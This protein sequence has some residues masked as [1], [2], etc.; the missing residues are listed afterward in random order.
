M[1]HSVSGPFKRMQRIHHYM[2][3][4]LI[5][6][7]GLAFYLNYS[8]NVNPA[9]QQADH[10]LQVIAILVAITFYLGGNAYLRKKIEWI[11]LGGAEVTAK[12]EGFRRA[13]V[14]QWSL[15]G[16]AATF[17][18]LSFLLVGNYAFFALAI[19]IA[20][21]LAMNAPGKSRISMLLQI[22]EEEIV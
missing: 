5:I 18:I 6:L 21:L 4:V 19:A 14:T 12:L 22:R 10:L 20:I 15:L 11:R 8:G 16:I 9:L 13:S 3:V 1:S 7:T 2:L 17:S